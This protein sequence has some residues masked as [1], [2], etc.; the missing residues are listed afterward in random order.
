MTVAVGRAAMEGQEQ[1][2]RSSSGARSSDASSSDS[3]AMSTVQ[4]CRQCSDVDSAAMSTVERCRWQ[5]QSRCRMEQQ[6]RS[7]SQ[8][9]CSLRQQ[10]M[11]GDG[12]GVQ[13]GGARRETTNQTLLGSL[14]LARG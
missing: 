11:S 5:R 10:P 14:E 12:E 3:A 6:W 8:M 4:R 1:F 7:S 9:I 13:V 2:I